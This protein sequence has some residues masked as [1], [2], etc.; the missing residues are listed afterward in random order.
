MSEFSKFFTICSAHNRIVK[1][2][3]ELINMEYKSMIKGAA[4]GLMAGTACY[5]ISRSPD[6]KKKTLKKNT[7][8]AVKAFSNAVSC[9]SSMMS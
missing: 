3:M 6:K 5:I 8:K 2:K 9:F 4:V 1:I 7:A